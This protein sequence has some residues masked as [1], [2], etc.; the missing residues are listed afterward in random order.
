M[1]P[2]F[3]LAEDGPL[4]SPAGQPHAELHIAFDDRR[5]KIT[6]PRKILAHADGVRR[7]DDG[8]CEL[9]RAGDGAWRPLPDGVRVR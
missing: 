6:G 2:A 7:L 8:T 5:V 4:A 1:S 9:R 3:S